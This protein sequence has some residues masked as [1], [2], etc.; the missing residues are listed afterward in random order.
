MKKKY[1]YGLVLIYLF[2]PIIID[3]FFMDLFVTHWNKGEWAGFLGS[4]LGGGIGGII[5][6]VGVWWQI[7]NEKKTKEKENKLGFLRHIRHILTRNLSAEDN[8]EINQ[9]TNNNFAKNT[10]QIFSYN[11]LS[12]TGEEPTKLL[13]EFNPKIIDENLNYLYTLS[14]AE[15]L[16][17]LNEKIIEFNK[18]YDFLFRNLSA[19]KEL[20][21][22]I[23]KFLLD[24]REYPNKSIVLDYINFLE[25]LS[26]LIYNLAVHQGNNINIHIDNLN[27]FLNTISVEDENSFNN[28]PVNLLVHLKSL[29]LKI[30]KKDIDYQNNDYIKLIMKIFLEVTNIIQSHLPFE[31]ELAKKLINY[32]IKEDK[33]YQLDIFKIFDEMEEILTDIEKEIKEIGN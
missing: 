27:D 19:K 30:N 7:T 3:I 5:T 2:L 21:S 10:C 18:L 26:N 8:T 4:Y 1:V 32:R 22:N 33:L 9:E 24:K 12:L 14:F 11:S 17:E 16:Y 6:L 23:Q 20:L 15:K 29:I 13:L 28:P 31:S 25:I